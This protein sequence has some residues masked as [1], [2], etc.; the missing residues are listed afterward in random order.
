ML[1][2]FLF[3]DV[4]WEILEDWMSEECWIEEDVSM[5]LELLPSLV[6]EAMILVDGLIMVFLFCCLVS[7]MV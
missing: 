5:I 3:W 2:L 7:W 6:L 1:S 4:P